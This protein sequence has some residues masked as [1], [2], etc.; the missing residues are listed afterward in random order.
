LSLFGKHGI[1]VVAIDRR[2]GDR[3]VDAVLIDN[4][5]AAY[6][7]VAHLVAQEYRRIGIIVGPANTTTAH[8][9]LAGYRRALADSGIAPDPQLERLGSFNTG[10]GR[11]LAEELLTVAPPIDALFTANN[12]LTQGALE[13]L[14]AHGLQ[15]PED[16]A[17]VGF[18]EFP[19]TLPGLVSLTT[20]TQP[21]YELGSVAANRLIQRLQHPG[22]VARQEIILAHHLR[23]GDSSRRRVQASL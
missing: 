18:D 10:S 1:S 3:S 5:A 19:W 4:V 11:R 21:A 7:A 13:A 8:E 14:H 6:E 22:A 20:V 12:R 16:I 9:R 15:V 17:V 2:V 23:M